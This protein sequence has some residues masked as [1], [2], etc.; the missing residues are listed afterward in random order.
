MMDFTETVVSTAIGLVVSWALTYAALPL[1][2]FDPSAG[3]AV[4]ITAMYTAASF[5]RQYAV[6]RAFRKIALAR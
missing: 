3:D 2:G 6:R 4:A 1:W 5:I